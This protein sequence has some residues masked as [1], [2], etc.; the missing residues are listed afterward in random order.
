MDI[1]E[2]NWI[3]S[4]YEKICEINKEKEGDRGQNGGAEYGNAVVGLRA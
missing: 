2:E 3:Y 4:V 1:E